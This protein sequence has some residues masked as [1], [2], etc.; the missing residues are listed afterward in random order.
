MKH[1]IGAGAHGLEWVIDGVNR[2]GMNRQQNAERGRRPLDD[3]Q[4]F[5]ER[6]QGD[7]AM[8]IDYLGG[9]QASFVDLAPEH[10]KFAA[11]HRQEPIDSLKVI[12]AGV[13]PGPLSHQPAHPV[14]L[15]ADPIEMS[16]K[17][18]HECW[19][20]TWLPIVTRC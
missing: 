17:M 9:F 14:V 3:R 6:A 2:I 18:R 8:R 12:A 5:A 13:D 11:E 20:G 10:R 7:L 16:G 19:S 4:Q 1:A 15:G